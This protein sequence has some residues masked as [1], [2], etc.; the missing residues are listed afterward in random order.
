MTSK[1]V[2]ISKESFDAA[3]ASAGSRG[4]PQERLRLSNPNVPNT[5]IPKGLF[6][7]AERVG[8]LD[9]ATWLCAFRAHQRGRLALFKLAAWEKQ[10][11]TDAAGRTYDKRVPPVAEAKAEALRQQGEVL[12]KLA[13]ECPQFFAGLL[14][15]EQPYVAVAAECR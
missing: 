15:E 6:P 13:A 2:N 3:R 9:L 1:Y 12:A 8:S 14:E 7:K 4:T 10:P 11:F 5:L